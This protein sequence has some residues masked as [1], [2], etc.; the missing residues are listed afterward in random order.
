MHRYA[1]VAGTTFVAQLYQVAV[2]D[3]LP[4]YMACQHRPAG[5]LSLCPQ[6]ADTAAPADPRWPKALKHGTAAAQK[7]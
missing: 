6:D 2:R 4:D 3:F 5:Q 7:S 1:G